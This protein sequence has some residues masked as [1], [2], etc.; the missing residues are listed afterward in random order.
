MLDR[1]PSRPLLNSSTVFSLTLLVLGL[2]VLGV[3]LFGLG[4]HHTFFQNSLLST[5]LLSVVFF[6]FVSV[7]LY[8][9]IKLRDT[10]GKVTDRIPFRRKKQNGDRSSLLN[11]GD[12]FSG[13]SNK[14]SSGSTDSSFDVGDLGGDEGCL[15]GILAVLAWVAAAVVLSVVLWLFGEV[16]LVA[17]FAFMAMLYWI[18]YRALRLVFRHSHQ[19]RGRG[20]ASLGYGL[21][22]TLL[23]NSW[24]YGIY[25]LLAYWRK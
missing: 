25:L 5:T 19:T 24:I 13:F 8:R 16:L 17:L 7:G 4:R 23:Y 1:N 9:G 11:L 6:G 20:W 15:A 12:F 14:S 2:T 18:F 10:L 3:Y 21:V 22:Y